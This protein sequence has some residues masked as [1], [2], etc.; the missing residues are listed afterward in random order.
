MFASGQTPHPV[1]SALRPFSPF[2]VIDTAPRT[3]RSFSLPFDVIRQ[4]RNATYQGI[5]AHYQ[6]PACERHDRPQRALPLAKPLVVD[7]SR[8]GLS[9]FNFGP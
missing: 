9:P 6:L 1:T 7:E 5:R 3:G 4:V 8:R 2:S